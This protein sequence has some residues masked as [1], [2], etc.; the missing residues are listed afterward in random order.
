MNEPDKYVPA[1]DQTSSDR[2][3]PATEG[4]YE[5]TFNNKTTEPIWLLE[6]AEGVDLYYYPEIRQV[7]VENKSTVEVEWI[8]SGFVS[9]G[10]GVAIPSGFVTPRVGAD[11]ILIKSGETGFFSGTGAYSIAYSANLN[12]GSITLKDVQVRMGGEQFPRLYHFNLNNT[13]F[14]TANTVQVSP[15]TMTAY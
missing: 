13:C 14:G 8:Y 5:R 12:N 7:V 3:V 11:P 4:I 6:I 1:S 10:S 15:I 2:Y 9:T